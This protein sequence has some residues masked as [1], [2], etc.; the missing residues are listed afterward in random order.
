MNILCSIESS[1]RPVHRQAG[2]DPCLAARAEA[3]F[4]S[5]VSASS[6]PSPAQVERAIRWA[7]VRYGGVPGCAA[8]VAF[9]YGDHPDTAVPRMRWARTVVEGIYTRRPMAA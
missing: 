7:L 5:D 6:R 9:A 4:A 1:V 3:L 8:E 2:T